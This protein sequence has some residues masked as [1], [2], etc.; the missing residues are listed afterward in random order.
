MR[1][2]LAAL[3][4]RLSP[5]EQKVAALVAADAGAVTRMNLAAVA[6]AAGVSEP[7]VIRFCRT[8]GLDGFSELRLELARA[9]GHGATAPRR[10]VTADTRVAEALHAGCGTAIARLAVLRDGLDHKA[11]EDAAR[12]LLA[13]RQVEIWGFGE[14]A[15]LAEAMAGRLF[16]LCRGVV[17]RGEARMQAMA[18]AGLEAGTVVLCLSALP[19][20]WQAAEAAAFA[21]AP[22]I[23]LAPAGSPLL[24]MATVGL[25]I[26]AGDEAGLAGPMIE[27]LALV[28]LAE[29]LA[30]A[31]TLLSSPAARER[32]ARMQADGAAGWQSPRRPL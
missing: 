14:T 29:S 21:G 9:E 7:T 30:L 27:H 17:A 6:K 8:L 13:A 2:R 12:R 15:P 22:L 31:V 32:A 16:G 28:A 18:A 25:G 5:A 4:G 26:A 23:A 11:I 19:D 20:A 3:H 1:D 10:T 24:A